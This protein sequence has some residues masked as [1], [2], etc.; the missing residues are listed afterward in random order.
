MLR[1]IQVGNQLPLQFPLA[2]EDTF[3][4]GMIAQLRVVGNEVVVGVSDGTAPIGIID[5]IRT[6]SFTRPQRDEVL[7]V[8]ATGVKGQDDQWRS[9]KDEKKELRYA[10]IVKSSF[11]INNEAPQVAL[12]EVNGVITVPAGSILNYDS[13]DDDIPDSFRIVVNY[14]YRVPEIPGEDS[15]VG[16]NR[17][18]VWIARGVFETDQYDMDAQYYVNSSLFV[19]L[20]GKLTTKQPTDEH[21]SVAMVTGPP[22]SI[23]RTLEL[24]WY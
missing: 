24:M 17:V 4:P 9:T 3:E 15:T 7:I 11:R 22:S 20:D 14:Y 2:G 23:V 21:P 19:G 12:N 5:D 8:P 18:T 16:S 10:S 6:T 1:P 13:D